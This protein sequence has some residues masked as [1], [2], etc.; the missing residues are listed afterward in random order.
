M[1]TCAILLFVFIA[2]ITFTSCDP[3]RKS[4]MP[5]EETAKGRL[6]MYYQYI[7]NAKTSSMPS[8]Y[9]E[10]AFM[11]LENIKTL[12]PDSVEYLLADS[13]L[14]IKD[15]T[16]AEI[17]S[18]IK[19]RKDRLE[20]SESRKRKEYETTLRNVFL[21][22]G[23]DIKVNIHGEKN[24][25]LTLTYVLFSDVWYRKFET[26]GLFTTWRS[27]GFRKITLRDGYDYYRIY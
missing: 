7:D 15:K 13:L 10:K 20:A 26:E 9:I 5:Y 6:E 2:L 19:V 22:S 17:D 25:Q 24:E 3:Q 14:I 18:I 16:M 23:L 21:D 8:H 4:R 11:E 12:Y 27:M 1:K